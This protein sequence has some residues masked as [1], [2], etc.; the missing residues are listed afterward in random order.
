MCSHSGIHTRHGNETSQRVAVNE[1]G[2]HAGS[3]EPHSANRCGKPGR[4]DAGRER[5]KPAIFRRHVAK[6]PQQVSLGSPA[7]QLALQTSDAALGYFCWMHNN[8][9]VV[10]IF[11]QQLQTV[12]KD[13]GALL[14]SWAERNL[15][16][17]QR[18]LGPEHPISVADVPAKSE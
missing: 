1:H 11:L 8:G 17:D 18:P 5:G 13:L 3:F 2:W 6:V 10:R 9:K 4:R 12:A 7:C 15:D 14:A 16:R